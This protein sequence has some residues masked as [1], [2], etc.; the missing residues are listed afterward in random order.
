MDNLS[1]GNETYRRL[2]SINRAT[3]LINRYFEVLFYQD[4][5]RI[6]VVEYP[7]GFGLWKMSTYK[8]KRESYTQNGKLIFGCNFDLNTIQFN[9][10][11]FIVVSDETNWEEVNLKW[12]SNP[13]SERQPAMSRKGK[14]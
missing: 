10:A 3:I 9:D 1:L 5:Q 2:Y 7:T 6:T 4:S 8:F 12:A 11:L 13:V 14:K